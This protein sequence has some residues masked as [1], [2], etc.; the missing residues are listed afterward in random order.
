[1]LL[2]PDRISHI[3]FDC[4]GTLIDWETG[5]LRALQPLFGGKRPDVSSEDLLRS[6]VRHEARLEAGPW[7]SYRQILREI[8]QAMAAEYDLSLSEPGEDLLSASLG[9]WPPFP[10]TVPALGQLK[11][12]FGLVVLSNI[13]GDLFEATARQLKVP[14]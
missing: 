8:L 11:K 3:T 14:F 13:D 9:S 7:K 2:E 1:M 6:Y 10:D 12:C 4:Y 5:I